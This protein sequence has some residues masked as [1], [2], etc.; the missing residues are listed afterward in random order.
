MEPTEKL[1]WKHYT[2]F[3]LLLRDQKQA[4]SV[5][6]TRD[7]SGRLTGRWDGYFGEW[8]YACR[9]RPDS[10]QAEAAVEECVKRTEP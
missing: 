10:K 8:E 1:E 5:V 6:Q 3:S 7:A 2:T 4:G 9:E